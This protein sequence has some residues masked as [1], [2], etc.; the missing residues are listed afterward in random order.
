VRTEEKLEILNNTKVYPLL[1]DL[2]DL[3]S[4]ESWPTDIDAAYYLVHSMKDASQ[5]LKSIEANA[6]Q[7]FISA[8]EKTNCAQ[9][10]YL[11]AIIEDETKLS[12]HLA[13]RLG[14]ETILKTSK[15]PLTI[16]RASIIIG[17]K[18]ASFQ[19]IH[20]L[21]ER[22]P[23]M[24][25]PKWVNSLC[26]PIAIEDVLFYLEQ[27]LFNPACY[28]KTFDIGG[29]EVLSFKELLLRYAAFRKLKRWI[30]TVPVLTPRLSSY[31]LLLITSVN[32]SICSYLVESMKENTRKCNK[33]IDIVLPHTCATF[34]E[35]VAIAC[36]EDVPAN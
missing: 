11:G 25:A 14:V 16:L 4:I 15:I 10:I 32:F 2:R 19:I 23:I 36:V 31:W 35:A 24:I 29:P 12:P 22:L 5:D 28:G 33:T 7:N 13:S 9:I 27:V 20:D 3:S 1:G 18:S 34:E 30:I 8:L 21:V 6:A 17:K 26:Q